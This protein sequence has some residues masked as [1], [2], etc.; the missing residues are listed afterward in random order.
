MNEIYN[1][2]QQEKETDKRRRMA[3]RRVKWLEKLLFQ[4]T[5]GKE[6]DRL[7]EELESAIS[8][9]QFYGIELSKVRG[10]LAAAEMQAAQTL[11]QQGA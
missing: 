5:N 2:R 9:A 7:N 6:F 1:L 3:A 4:S 11:A 10:D 8:T